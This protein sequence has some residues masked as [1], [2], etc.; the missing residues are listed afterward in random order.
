LLVCDLVF[1]KIVTAKSKLN[2]TIHFKADPDLVFR[3]IVT[4]KKGQLLFI[5]KLFMDHNISISFLKDF[6]LWTQEELK[7]K[8]EQQDKY[9]EYVNETLSDRIKKLN[10]KIPSLSSPIEEINEFYQICNR[11]N[12]SIRNGLILAGLYW[13]VMKSQAEN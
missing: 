3:K 13:S 2:Q 8:P 7:I 6:Q 11:P 1:R 10:L 9:L 5:R 4:A 12:H